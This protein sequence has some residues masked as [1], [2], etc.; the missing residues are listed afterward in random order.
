MAITQNEIQDK[1]KEMEFLE[2]Q[3]ANY[4]AYTQDLADFILPRKAW[5][6][7]IRTKGERLKF[8]FLY[9]S[10]AIRALRIMAAGFH[11]NLTNPSTRWFALETEDDL[12]MQIEAVKVFFR[13]AENKI[14]KRLNGSNFYNIIQEFYTDY[15]GFGTGTFLKLKDAKEKVRFESIP[16]Q[17]TNRV[18]DG[19][20][21]LSEFYRH[22]RLTARQAAG[23]WGEDNLGKSIRDS[24]KKSP[25]EEFWFIHNVSERFKRDVSK[26]DAVN[27]PFQSLWIAQKDQHLM[28]ESGFLRMPY[29]SEVFY[30][31]PNDPNGFSPAMDEF[32]E[33]KLVNA[34]KRT[35]IR[36]GMKQADPPMV[37]P[38]RGFILPLNFNPAAMNYR[39]AKTSADD[40]QA[41]PVG[42]GQSMGINVEL[43]K[44]EQENI[45]AGMFVPLFRSLSE[46]TKQMTIPE[47]QRRVAENMVLLGPVIG[48]TT[49]GILGPLIIDT[50]F[51]LLQ[52]GELGEIPIEIEDQEFNPVYLSPLAKAQRA[53]EIG[54]I[55]AFLGDVQAISTV[56]PQ[57]ADK[58]NEDRTVEELARIR[59]VNPRIMNEDEEIAQ[60]RKQRAEQDQL[61]AAMQAGQSVAGMAKDGAQAQKAT[62]D[63]GGQA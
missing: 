46:I 18:L 12:L 6:T 21:R 63:A 37:M 7:S 51:D 62:A 31:D 20:G 2:N 58:V 33:I 22:F 14:L 60:I 13:N 9:D 40:I 54:D 47:V 1:V 35:V 8:N 3:N 23:L 36:A 48:R 30:K 56:L 4:R 32:P 39:D 43:I 11:S 24:L 44:L 41:L 25:F 38:S 15:G 57:A 28:K 53:S 42:K 19:R 10:T 26:S 5:I 17:E 55:Q 29:Y 49:H 50:F 45:E 27:M 59:G 61:I 52:E 16:V 34:M